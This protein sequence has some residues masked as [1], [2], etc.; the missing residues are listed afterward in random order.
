ML[1]D[2][3]QAAREIGISERSLR[4]WACKDKTL[5]KF[6]VGPGERLVRFDTEELR[7]W[8]RAKR[9]DRQP[10]SRGGRPRSEL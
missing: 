7:E 6:K 3:K 2:S 10:R 4:E 9:E 8:L 5:P 1:V